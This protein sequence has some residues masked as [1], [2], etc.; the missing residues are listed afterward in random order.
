MPDRWPK[1]GAG[2]LLEEQNWRGTD[3]IAS[4]SQHA[5][6]RPHN[7]CYVAQ[8]TAT[9]LVHSSSLARSTNSSVYKVPRGDALSTGFT[10]KPSSSMKGEGR[11]LHCQ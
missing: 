1:A 9:G 5:Q 8:Q 10:G 3:R 2:L 6:A 7:T 11:G 4:E